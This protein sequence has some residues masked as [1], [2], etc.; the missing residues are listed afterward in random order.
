MMASETF[1]TILVTIGLA[2]TT[3]A[4]VALIVLL[5][6]DWVKGKLW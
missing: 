6:R 2:I 3:V 1:L 4:P 5:V